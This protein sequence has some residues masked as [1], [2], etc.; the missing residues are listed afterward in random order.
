MK[1][2]NEGRWKERRERRQRSAAVG[3]YKGNS[4]KEEIKGWGGDR[5]GRL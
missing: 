4:T 3:V 1:L 2:D 5:G